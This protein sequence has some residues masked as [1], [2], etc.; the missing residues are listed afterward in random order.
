VRSCGSFVSVSRCAEALGG[1]VGVYVK[2]KSVPNSCA[3][4]R[5]PACINNPRMEVH[6]HRRGRYE[7]KLK[8]LRVCRSETLVGSQITPST[9][10]SG[11]PPLLAVEMASLPLYGAQYRRLRIALI[12]VVTVFLLYALVSSSVGEDHPRGMALRGDPIKTRSMPAEDDEEVKDREE[13]EHWD[14]LP[15]TNSNNWGGTPA[16]GGVEIYP[17]QVW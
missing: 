9:T 10:I 13:I 15:D 7:Q 17:L 2:E 1:A 8:I 11:P 4:A 16:K 6:Q 5:R 14:P 3:Y 12:V